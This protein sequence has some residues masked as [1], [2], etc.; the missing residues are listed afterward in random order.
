MFSTFLYLL[1]NLKWQI[2]QNGGETFCIKWDLSI[3]GGRMFN[4]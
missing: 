2:L 4:F 3:Y 1:T